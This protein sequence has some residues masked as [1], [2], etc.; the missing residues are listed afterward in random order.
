MS[1]SRLGVRPAGPVTPEQTQVLRNGDIII[2]TGL[3][4][5]PDTPTTV[6]LQASH[7]G[8][9]TVLLESEVGTEDETPM[10]LTFS[11]DSQFEAAV[12][13][14]GGVGGGEGAPPETLHYAA[15]SGSGVTDISAMARSIAEEVLAEAEGVTPGRVREIAREEAALDAQDWPDALSDPVPFALAMTGAGAIAG[16][17]GGL[18]A[19][20]IG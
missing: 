15:I 3:V 5:N 9:P 16:V 13:G 4:E 2:E 18:L 7:A 8:S 6:L 20:R 19:T 17:G 10:F 12:R 1:A 14:G 11:D